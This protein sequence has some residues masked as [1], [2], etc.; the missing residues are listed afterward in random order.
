MEFDREGHRYDSVMTDPNSGMISG[1]NNELDGDYYK[2]R[3][4][5][6]GVLE[7]DCFICHMP[8]YNFSARKEQIGK[9]NFRWAATA[10]SGLASVAGSVKEGTPV[11]VDYDKSCFDKDGKLS[12]IL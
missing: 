5:R 1:G 10:G 3:W 11:K 7:A 12:P 9:L 8:E 4:D 6:S 2:A